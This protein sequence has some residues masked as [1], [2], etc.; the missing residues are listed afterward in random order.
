MQRKTVAVVGATGELG[1][2]VIK[3]LLQNSDFQ[4]KALVRRKVDDLDYPSVNVLVVDFND[5]EVLA[6][7]LSDVY[8]V[9]CTLQGLEDVIVDL[10][11]RVFLAALKAKVV[12]FIPSDFAINFDRIPVGQNRNFDIRRRFHSLVSKY[13]KEYCAGDYYI[14]TT[15]I[16]QGAFM[17]LVM[18]PE[19]SIDWQEGICKFIGQESTVA[20]FTTIPNT[21]EYTAYCA[22]DPHKTPRILGIAGDQ[23][24]ARVSGREI[25]PR[26][27]MSVST[28]SKVIPIVKFLAPGKKGEVMPIWQKMMY[29]LSMGSGLSSLPTLDNHFYNVK[30]TKVEEY[31]KQEYPKVAITEKQKS[32]SVALPLGQAKAII[33]RNNPNADITN[34]VLLFAGSTFVDSPGI[35]AAVTGE[36]GK[37]SIVTEWINVDWLV[38][39]VGLAL[40]VDTLVGEVRIEIVGVAVVKCA[41]LKAGGIFVIVVIFCER[42]AS[43][44]GTIML[45]GEANGRGGA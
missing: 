41:G 2:Q 36:D 22:T 33:A 4:V 16:M 17:E 37:T 21:A 1:R 45:G 43:G 30:W 5:V 32:N 24:A 14:Q 25:K 20:D 40:I 31:M 34:I 6:S 8:S 27:I 7:H 9:V 11:G 38:A 39:D 12:R 42:S 10:Q 13:V 29:G 28:L 26:R 35:L 15:S 23:I 19:F 18:N 44:F 3:Y